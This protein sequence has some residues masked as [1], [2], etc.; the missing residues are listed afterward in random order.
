MESRFKPG[1]P[2]ALKGHPDW[3]IGEVHHIRH[4]SARTDNTVY[5]DWK[6]K[7][8]NCRFGH[9]ELELEPAIKC[10]F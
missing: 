2:V 3:G 1:M 5:V 7:F 10:E 9:N 8:Y 6:W 4:A